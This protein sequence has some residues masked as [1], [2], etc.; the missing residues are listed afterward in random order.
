MYKKIKTL[1]QTKEMLLTITNIKLYLKQ[2][3]VQEDQNFIPN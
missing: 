2:S 3:H 1:F